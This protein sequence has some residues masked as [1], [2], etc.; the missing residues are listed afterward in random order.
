MRTCWY[1][2]VCRDYK[3]PTK[4]TTPGDKELQATLTHPDDSPS[5]NSASTTTSVQATCRSAWQAGRRCPVNFVYSNAN[6]TLSDNSLGTF[7]D[8]CCVSVYRVA[9]WPTVL[10]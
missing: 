2:T 9:H 5:D 10:Q 8:E 7:I 6:K 4:I 1:C 3:I